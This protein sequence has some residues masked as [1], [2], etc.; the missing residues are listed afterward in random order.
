[1]QIK[2][3]VN[4][5]KYNCQQIPRLTVTDAVTALGPGKYSTPKSMY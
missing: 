3:E 4:P 2:L 1:M 5:M